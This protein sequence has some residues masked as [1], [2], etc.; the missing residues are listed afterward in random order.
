MDLIKNTQK[1]GAGIGVIIILI[2]LIVGGIY[3]WQTQIKKEAEEVPPEE[4][5]DQVIDEE[6][7]EALQ[8]EDVTGDIEGLEEDL[9]II[10][11]LDEGLVEDLGI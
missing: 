4:V 11:E 2:I 10:D 6:L 8:V 5:T 1:G 7:D 3:L 9:Q